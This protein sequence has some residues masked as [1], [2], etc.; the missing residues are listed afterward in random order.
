MILY[1][2]NII[3]I[4]ELIQIFC[5]YGGGMHTCEQK[6]IQKKGST[7]G[8]CHVDKLCMLANLS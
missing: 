3:F 7:L 2:A 4:G 1:E 8:H 6:S 5:L